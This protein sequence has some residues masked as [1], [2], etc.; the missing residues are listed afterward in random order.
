MLLDRSNGDTTAMV[1]RITLTPCTPC[2]KVIPVSQSNPYAPSQSRKH[3]DL[4]IRK[5]KIRVL[6][7][8]RR[9]FRLLG[10]QYWLFLGITFLGMLIG[11]AVPMGLIMGPVLVGIYAC[12]IERERTGRADFQTM[13]K[14]FENFLEPFLAFL[15]ILAVGLVVTLPLMIAMFAILFVPIIQAANAAGPNGPPPVM[16][17]TF[18]FTMIAFYPVIIGVNILVAL[19][20]LFTFQLIADR[21]LKGIDAIKLS[22]QGTLKNFWGVLWALIVVTFVSFLGALM[23]Y[24]PLFLLMPVTFGV[25]YMLYRDIYGPLPVLPEDPWTEIQDAELID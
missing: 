8:F 19:P 11:S 10:D 13:F 17:P 15:V 14:G 6:D 7:L 22:I 12:F 1:Q 25:F 21:N 4:G 3:D 16:P 2:T 5:V 20:F 18:F 23:C 24:I 9:S